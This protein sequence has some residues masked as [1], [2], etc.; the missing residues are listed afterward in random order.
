MERIINYKVRYAVLDPHLIFNY[1]APTERAIEKHNARNGFYT[2]L[3]ASILKDG[4]RNPII[5]VSGFHQKGN[6]LEKFPEHMRGS[7]ILYCRDCGCSRLWVAQKN[8]IKIP[9]LIADS[10]DR[11]SDQLLLNT[12]EE[13]L[14]YFTDEISYIK[15]AKNRI[16]IG[17][18]ILI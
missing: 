11:F 5:V 2:Q 4:I 17:K 14:K 13:V 1:N 16:I 12:K 7:N 18:K 15:F 8:N 9:C 3:E 10:N 6:N